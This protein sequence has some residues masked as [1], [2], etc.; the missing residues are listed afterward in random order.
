MIACGLF[1]QGRPIAS[2][3]L[4]V[5]LRSLLLTRGR[6]CN[7]L[8]GQL[9]LLD[10]SFMD[11]SGVPLEPGQVAALNG[12][13]AVELGSRTGY[14]ARHDEL[15]DSAWLPFDRWWGREVVRSSAGAGFSRQQIV[16]NVAETD[17]GAH[18]DKRLVDTYAEFARTRDSTENINLGGNGISSERWLLR[19][20]A[21]EV[22]RTLE[23][24]RPD[25]F[26]QLYQPEPAESSGRG[27]VISSFSL[28]LPTR[29]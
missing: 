27:V 2:K 12:L 23:R 8:L 4:S 18:V 28:I 26:R 9:G 17:G 3:W 5:Q 16:C 11:T 25:A 14:V 19:Q 13:V 29:D 15:S 22:L 7:A 6:T 24:L 1:D 10:Q 21:H 20:I